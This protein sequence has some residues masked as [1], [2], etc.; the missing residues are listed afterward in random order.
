M[1][2]PEES[3]QTCVGRWLDQPNMLVDW[4]GLRPVLGR[5]GIAPTVAWVSDV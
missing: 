5:Y 2:L 3:L 1:V 4:A